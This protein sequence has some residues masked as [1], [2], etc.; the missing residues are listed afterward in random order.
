MTKRGFFN[1]GDAI[2]DVKNAYGAKD[3]G[4]ATLSLVGKGLFNVARFAVTEGVDQL[5]KTSG[6]KILESDKSTDEQKTTARRN[7]ELADNRIR[8]RREKDE[9]WERSKNE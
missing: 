5:V 8:D 2:D 6:K 3:T 9:E 4:I 7:I 1:L